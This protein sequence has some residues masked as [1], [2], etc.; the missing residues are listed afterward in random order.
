MGAQVKDVREREREGESERLMLTTIRDVIDDFLLQ[1]IFA[2]REKSDEM[3]L[4]QGINTEE[5]GSR[6][7]TCQAEE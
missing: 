1:M 7:E 4:V 6:S 3:A 2:L 5:C